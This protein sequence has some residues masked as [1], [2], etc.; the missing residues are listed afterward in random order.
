[1]EDLPVEW[2]LLRLIRARIEMNFQ[3]R[4]PLDFDFRPTVFDLGPLERSA[5]ENR[6]KPG[7]WMAT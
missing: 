4:R 5:L 6:R 2:A 7:V 3:R 1:M